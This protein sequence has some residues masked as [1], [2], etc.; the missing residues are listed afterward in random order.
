MV[1][2]EPNE[3]RCT[4]FGHLQRNLNIQYSLSMKKNQT[5]VYSSSEVYF[6][7]NSEM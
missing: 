2:L 3:S 4:I 6:K 1:G 7:V 5:L